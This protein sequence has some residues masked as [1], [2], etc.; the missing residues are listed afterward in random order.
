M[1]NGASSSELKLFDLTN[2]LVVGQRSVSNVKHVLSAWDTLFAVQGKLFCLLRRFFWR[3]S[4]ICPLVGIVSRGW[5]CFDLEA[6][7]IDV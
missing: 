2:K 6:S 1:P 4:L 5:H 7:L 3:L